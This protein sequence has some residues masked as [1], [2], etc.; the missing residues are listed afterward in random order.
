MDTQRSLITL[1]ANMVLPNLFIPGAGKSGTSSLH[2]YLNQHPDI[3]MSRIKEPH[4]FCNDSLYF[5][6]GAKK[7]YLSLF[8]EGEN[9]KYRGESST[10]YMA[11]PHTIERIKKDINDPMFIFILRNPIYRAFSHYNWARSFGGENLDFRNALLQH[12]NEKPDAEKQFRYGYKYYFQFGLYGKYLQRF[13]DNFDRRNIF[14]ITT[15]KLKEFPL[16]T[17]NKCFNFLGVHP[18][19]QVKDVEVNKTRY[20]S[21]PDL[22]VKLREFLMS[23]WIPI[24][25][26]KII[27]SQIK[28]PFRKIKE[29]I[30]AKSKK[31]LETPEKPALSMEDIE[32]LRDLYLKDVFKL[33]R[34]TGY[35]FEEWKEFNS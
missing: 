31:I 20:C 8:E 26:R 11:F 27:P 25:Y 15:E 18:L 9:C 12:I 22:L 17:L 14:I 16:S 2:E 4:F 21:H 6:I 35:N 30:I 5:D 34:L 19:S 3:Y 10:G 23:G 32:W 13:Y 29:I 28:A 24:K 7:E 33:K 1:E